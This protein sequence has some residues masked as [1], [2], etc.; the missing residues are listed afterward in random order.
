ML[1]MSA[2]L[3]VLCVMLP[4]QLQEDTRATRDAQEI[5]AALDIQPIAPDTEPISLELEDAIL[6]A[7]QNNLTIETARLS[8]EAALEGFGSAW[9]VYDSTFFGEA[10]W[11]ESTRSPT[12]ATVLGGTTFPGST[13]NTLT[14]SWRAGVRGLLRT[15]TTWQLDVG[16]QRFRNTELNAVDFDMGQVIDIG[17]VELLDQYTG[18]WSL[19]LTHPLLRND[20]DFQQQGLELAAIDAL[21]ATAGERRAAQD[22]LTEV[23]T[24]YWNLTFALKDLETTQL[25]VDLATELLSITRSIFRQGLRNRID[26][27]E[28]EAEQAQRREELISAVNTARQADDEV[29]RLVFA[30]RGELEWLRSIIPVTEADPEAFVPAVD[31]VYALI[32]RALDRRPEI[33]EARY[34]IERADIEVLRAEDQAESQLDIS[35]SWGLNSNAGGHRRAFNGLDD[36]DF[37]DTTLGI[38]WEVPIGNRAAGY[39]LR[40]A[41]VE[42]RR[43]GVL[44]REAEINVIT[45]VRREARNVVLLGESVKAA[46]ETSRLNREVYEGERRRLENDLS[47][48]FKVRE[49]LRNYLDALDAELRAQLDLEV[50]KVSLASAQGTLLET[51]GLRIDNPNLDLEEAPPSGW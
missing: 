2:I 29:R 46:A 42:R 8:S 15:G 25:S 40:R 23:V 30:P 10:N 31:D 20:G 12:Q 48:P 18:D 36:G 4:L 13:T 50:A 39:A 33:Q 49:T 38:T 26:V 41:R 16:T 11:G 6:L 37:E 35:G 45:D 24:A 3:A 14:E 32:D 5:L 7:F 27:I 1:N 43:A 47:T 44:L 19:S 22:T 28:A 34:G 17:D 51:Y 21:I 9:G